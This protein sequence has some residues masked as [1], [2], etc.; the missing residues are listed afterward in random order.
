MSIES[1]C[2]CL[3]SLCYVV[4]I[5]SLIWKLEIGLLPGAGLLDIIHMSS[6]WPCVFYFYFQLVVVQNMWCCLSVL[7]CCK[8]WIV[9]VYKK[10][11]LIESSDVKPQFSSSSLLIQCRF[12]VSSAFMQIW[13]RNGSSQQQRLGLKLLGSA[14]VQYQ[15]IFD[16]V[17]DHTGSVTAKLWF[18]SDSELAQHWF[19]ANSG[20][21]LFSTSS[22]PIQ[23]LCLQPCSVSLELV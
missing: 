23:C 19:R 8:T 20:Q 22:A 13:F 9:M 11:F 14:T 2:A 12:N 16:L 6:Q 4:Y 7:Y 10:S 17:R 15:F 21:S 3:A 18:S 5:T 1:T